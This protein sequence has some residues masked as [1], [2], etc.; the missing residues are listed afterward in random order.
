MGMVHAGA[1]ERFSL[2][3]ICISALNLCVGFLFFIRDPVKTHGTPTAILASLPSLAIAGFALKLAAP[4]NQW[5]AW[6]EGVFVIGTALAVFAFVYLGRS[7][8]LLPAVRTIVSNGPFRVI[9]HPAYAG[10]FLMTLACG[11]S[12]PTATTAWPAMI[13][14]PLIVMRIFAEESVL[15]TDET[16][17]EYF[18]KVR[19]RLF[20]GIW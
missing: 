7:F 19:W 6:L 5:S 13:I 4:L 2:V 12:Q 14:L 10:E 17:Q 1:D 18:E 9:R 8:A 11:L 15:K 3:R 20:P 16:Y